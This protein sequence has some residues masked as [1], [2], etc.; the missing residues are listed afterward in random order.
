MTHGGVEV[1]LQ[2]SRPRQQTRDEWSASRPC[3]FTPG[4]HWIGGWMGPTVGL[5]VVE[6]RK[7]SCPWRETKPGR[8]ARSPSVCRPSYPVTYA[9]RVVKIRVGL[10]RSIYLRSYVK[11]LHLLKDNYSFIGHVGI[12]KFSIRKLTSVEVETFYAHARKKR[13]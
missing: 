13:L 7:I 2:H 5:E 3:R 11:Y 8:P 12:A 9:V 1:Q 6:N 4:I 10:T